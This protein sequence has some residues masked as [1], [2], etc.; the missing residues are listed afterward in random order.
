MYKDRGAIGYCSTLKPIGPGPYVFSDSIRKSMGVK[1][2]K[3]R[4]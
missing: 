2:P 1:F 4:K 3:Y